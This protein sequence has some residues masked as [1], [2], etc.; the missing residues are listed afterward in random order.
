M[1]IV[2]REGKEIIDS[3]KKDAVEN[4]SLLSKFFI[5]TFANLKSYIFYYW[6]AFPAPTFFN[7]NNLNRSKNISEYFNDEQL[8][9]LY[10]GYKNK[11]NIHNKGFFFV[12]LKN[13]NIE[14]FSLREG[15]NEINGEENWFL[16]FSDTSSSIYPSWPLRNFIALLIYHR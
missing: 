11:L 7:C 5:L 4:P 3:I 8:D 16:G 13:E 14:L 1:D 6:F 15:L 2:N 10:D 9:C 12:R